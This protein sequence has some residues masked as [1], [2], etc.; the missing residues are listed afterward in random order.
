[1][2]GKHRSRAELIVV[3]LLRAPRLLCRGRIGPQISRRDLEHIPHERTE[4]RERE[5]CVALQCEHRAE[6]DVAAL[7]DG[8]VVADEGSGLLLLCL[9]KG[10]PLC[11]AGAKSVFECGIKCQK[12]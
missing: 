11:A 12:R 4:R 3:G 2:L 9:G 10:S 1:M 8:L 6:S 5:P 7:L